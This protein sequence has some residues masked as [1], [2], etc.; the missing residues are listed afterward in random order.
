MTKSI[1][2][3]F[4]SFLSFLLMAQNAGSLDL[5]FGTGGKV[6]TSISAGADKA[7]ATVIQSDGKIIVAGYTSSTITGKDFACVRYNANGTLDNS[8]GVSGIVTTDLQI[9][10]DDIAYS[11]TLQTD[12]KL[13][14]A[15]YSDNGSNKSAAIVRYKTNGTVD[16]TFGTNG[17]VFTDFEPSKQDEIKVIKFHALTGKI[18]V[19][20]ASISSTTISKPVVAR[21]NSNGTLDTTFNHT[22][23]RLL[24]VTNLDYQ[25]LFSVEDLSVQSNGKIYAAG[26][27]DFPSMSWSADYWAAKINSD[28]TMDN[29]FSSDGVVTFNGTFNGNDKAYSLLLKSNNNIV[30]GGSSYIGDL[31]YRYNAFEVNSTANSVVSSYT[32]TISSGFGVNEIAYGLAE[33]LNGKLVLAGSTGTTSNKSFGIT[34]ANADFTNDATFNGTG[35]TTTTFGS[36]ALSEAFDVAIQQDDNKIVAVGYTGNDFAI[37]RYLGTTIPQLDSLR[38]LTPADLSV[39]LDTFQ[40]LDWSTAPGATQYQFSIDVSS[41]FNVNPTTTL[42]SNSSITVTQLAYN[43]TYFWRVRATDGTNFGNWTTP[44]QFKTKAKVVTA[45]K[46]RQIE[47]MSIYP[48]PVKNI[49]TVSMPNLVEKNARLILFSVNGVS[50]KEAV[51]SSSQLSVD[52]ANLPAGAYIYQIK[53]NDDVV[54]TGIIDVAK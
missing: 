29:T 5:G 50:V 16:S 39:N 6:I 11:I 12:G 52:V 14:V 9:G 18:I 53:F 32:K 24:W 34:R 23:I 10:S 4:F 38:L 43:T 41:N 15:G 19:G 48:N 47:N 37:A 2:T 3:L 21:Y 31:Y 46:N 45:V 42:L 35:Y 27:R 7:Y 1:F 20:G 28:G 8:F 49:L 54:K 40:T 13:L 26:W 17:K 22:G 51:F 33:D 36:N 44:W 25:Y 30:I